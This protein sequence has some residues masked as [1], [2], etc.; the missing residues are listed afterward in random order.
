MFYRAHEFSLGSGLGLYIVKNAIE[1]VNGSIMLE[2]KKD[3]GFKF[4]V[5]VPDWKQ[6]PETDYDEN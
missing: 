5:I 2:S 1:K 6:P 3:G 4:D